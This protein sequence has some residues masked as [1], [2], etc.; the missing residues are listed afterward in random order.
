VTPA[1]WIFLVKWFF[2]ISNMSS[3]CCIVRCMVS[4]TSLTDQKT[5]IFLQPCSEYS[6]ILQWPDEDDISIVEIFVLPT[7]SFIQHTITS[8]WLDSCLEIRPIK[9]KLSFTLRYM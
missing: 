8:F 6:Y 2:K 5:V 7:L 4:R 3:W 1:I 9:I